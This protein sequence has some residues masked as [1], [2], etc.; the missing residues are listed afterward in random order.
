M[1]LDC[2]PL[3][4]GRPDS[5]PFAAISSMPE[6]ESARSRLFAGGTFF[7]SKL[8]SADTQ[9]PDCNNIS[10]EVTR[11]NPSLEGIDL[12]VYFNEVEVER[13]SVTQD[14]NCTAPGEPPPPPG[15]GN[16]VAIPALRTATTD[17]LY[18]S[19]PVR[20]TDLQDGGTTPP[21]PIIPTDDA[22]LSE[23]EITAMTGGS[24]SLAADVPNIDTGPDRTMTYISTHE[25]DNGNPV[26]PPQDEKLQQFDFDNDAFI[27]Y[28][29]NADCRI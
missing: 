18:I 3:Y 24:G 12:V 15:I 14:L 8:T 11:P 1:P 29:P 22:C 5:D 7:R 2:S 10:L 27:S 26:E 28:V 21:P 13:Y 16:D 9:S 25:D 23:F 4:E 19:M 17:S 6:Y 20:G